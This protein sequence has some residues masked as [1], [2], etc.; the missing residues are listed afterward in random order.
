MSGEDKYRNEGTKT[1]FQEW[2]GQFLISLSYVLSL[3]GWASAAGEEMGIV[4]LV[5]ATSGASATYIVD[6][7][8]DENFYSAKKGTAYAQLCVFVPV[9]L[10]CCFYETRLLKL[11]AAFVLLAA[12]YDSPVPLLGVKFKN[13]FPYSKTLF[14]P[15]MHVGWCFSLCGSVPPIGVGIQMLLNF[16]VLNIA[17][18][19]K[20]IESDRKNGVVTVPNTIG[21]DNTMLFLFYFSLL[22]SLTSAAAGNVASVVQMLYMAAVFWAKKD[23]EAPPNKEAMNFASVHGVAQLFLPCR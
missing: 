13:L 19:M 23:Q 8:G 20:D 9:C 16:V 15:A 10:A 1:S 5:A 22:L 12:F 3:Q 2:F 11:F 7:L 18:D 17:M 4:S 14:V 21:K 6:H